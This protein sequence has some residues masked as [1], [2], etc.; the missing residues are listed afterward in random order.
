MLAYER[1]IEK[2]FPE[3]LARPDIPLEDRAVV[4]SLIY[5][6]PRFPYM[7]R[8]EFA[9]ENY[10]KLPT[11]AFNQLMGYPKNSRMHEIYVHE[12]GNEGN[13]ELLIARG[14]IDRE[15][16]ISSAQIKLQPKYCPI[17]HKPNKQEAFF[18]S[19][20]NWVIGSLVKKE[21]AGGKRKRRGS[22]KESR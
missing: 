19:K 3:L 8:H 12:L 18:C 20:C 7:R 11:S 16:T 5:D 1:T 17:C 21:C 6:K 10:H 9:S 22:S 2:H 13:R 14:I 15:E 4:R